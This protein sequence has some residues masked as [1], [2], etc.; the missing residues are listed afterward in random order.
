MG[1]YKTDILFFA[2][3]GF[4]HKF[5]NSS[6]KMFIKFNFFLSSNGEI[7]YNFIIGNKKNER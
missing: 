7:D 2:L 4:L 5:K 6:G 3:M 1:F